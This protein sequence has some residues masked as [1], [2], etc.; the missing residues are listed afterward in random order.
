MAAVRDGRFNNRF[1]NFDPIVYYLI[2]LPQLR[3]NLTK[4]P[5]QFKSNLT[6]KSTLTEILDGVML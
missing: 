3:C 1:S 6:E 5:L 4:I 2:I